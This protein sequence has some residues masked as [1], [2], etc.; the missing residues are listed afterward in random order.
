MNVGLLIKISKMRLN[1]K[2][3]L[4]VLALV[5]F[6]L[7]IVLPP[8]I[9][10][11][12]YPSIGDDT[13]VHLNILDRVKIGSPV[14]VYF[15]EYPE[16][17]QIRYYSYYIIGYPM[18]FISDVSG[19]SKDTLFFWFN[20]VALIGVGLSLFFIF[21]KLVNLSAGLLAL[22]I[23]IFTSYSVLLLFYSGVIFNIINIGIILPF[24]CYFF[25][26]WMMTNKKRYAIGL[27]TLLALF[28]VFH[29]TGIYLPFIVIMGLIAY[30]VYRIR[31]KQ[32]IPKKYIVIG[33]AII[34]CVAVLFL[35]FNLV[36]DSIVYEMTKP[37]LGISGLLLLNESLFHYMSPFVVAILVISA[38][39]LIWKRQ[40]L[41]VGEKLS[42][43][44]FGLLSVIML[45]AIFGLS[46]QPFRQGYDFAILLSILVVALVGIVIRLDKSRIVA[47]LLVALA[48]GGSILN[49]GNWIGG[50]NSALEKVDVEAINYVNGMKGDYYSVSENIDYWIYNRYV[51]KEYME[52][53]GHI[54]ITR[55]VPMRSKV[56]FSG[57][58][59]FALGSYGEPVAVFIGDGVEIKIYSAIKQ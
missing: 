41:T 1:K 51:D 17:Y 58:D 54:A 26:Q 32:P 34:A 42:I 53:G 25:I 6:A 22:L 16:V 29:S 49:I 52:L 33:S 48:V 20:Y 50:Y 12:V 37:V 56:S 39:W 36:L 8:I 18:D 19:V 24:A 10:G 46:P 14:S 59:V 31:K 21:K 11:Y 13:A 15:E 40:Q 3:C 55:D 43:W 2:L 23:P 9:H 57:V 27:F 28:A 7:I 38:I 47:I 4:A 45:P 35:K 44:S 5:V 30:L